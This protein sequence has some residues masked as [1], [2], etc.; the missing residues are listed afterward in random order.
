MD[1]KNQEGGIILPAK[2]QTPN[3]LIQNHKGILM[4]VS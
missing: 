4:N 1:K 3:G 2:M